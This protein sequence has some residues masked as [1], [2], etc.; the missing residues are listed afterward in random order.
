MA[1]EHEKAVKTLLRYHDKKLRDYQKGDLP[2]HVVP[3]IYYQT[4]WH[5]MVGA[6]LRESRGARIETLFEVM[7]GI[8]YSDREHYYVVG[9]GFGLL[10]KRLES[11]VSK[12]LR[13]N[14][15]LD[16]F[17][18]IYESLSPHAKVIAAHTFAVWIT[19]TNKTWDEAKW[20]QARNWLKNQQGVDELFRDSILFGL[21][22]REL[23]AY[24]IRRFPLNGNHP[25]IKTL[26]DVL[27]RLLGDPK[28]PTPI[29][30]GSNQ[31]TS[32]SGQRRHSFR[33]TFEDL[34]SAP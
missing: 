12:K 31:K 23:L 27:P 26:N 9:N 14:Q 15:A 18:S 29:P 19:N 22:G 24:Q 34:S 21:A 1:G 33:T 7:A 6:L 5:Q 4:H 13:P 28:V 11:S 32:R 25:Q 20:T 3:R 17:L 30:S 10:A 16:E 8:F 2:E